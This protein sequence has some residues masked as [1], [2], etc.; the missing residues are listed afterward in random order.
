MRFFRAQPGGSRGPSGL[1]L[2]AAVLLALV[3]C[4]RQKASAP[5]PAAP[6]EAAP[7]QV[8]VAVQPLVFKFDEPQPWKA[9][10]GDTTVPPPDLEAE[11][12]RVLVSQREPLQRKTPRWQSLPARETVELA[13]PPGAKFRCM[14]AP[15]SVTSEGDDFGKSLEA[16]HLKRSFHCSAD[17]FMTWTETVLQVRLDADGSRKIIGPDAGILLRQREPDGSV[18]ESFVLMR[19]DKEKI[20]A[21]TGPP[22]FI[23]PAPE[24]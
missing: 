6:A 24:D 3:A 14:V 12:W 15:L 10:V 20:H 11:T 22:K 2:C 8:A 19:S 21:T 17:G 5:A 18:R 13:M 9:R 16:W 23:G 7:P 1:R 4:D